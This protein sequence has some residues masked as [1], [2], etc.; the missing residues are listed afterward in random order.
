[1][2]ITQ[3]IMQ[4]KQIIKAVFTTTIAFVI[5]S[6]NSA[7]KDKEATNNP[8]A[9]TA[10]ATTPPPPPPT[11]DTTAAPAVAVVKKCFSND[12]LKYNTVITVNYISTSEVDGSVTSQEMGSDKKEVVKFTGKVSGDKL[13]IK[14]DGK[15]PVIGDASEW[16]NNPW[17][18][19]NK[20]GK[21]K[22]H[23]IFNAKNYETNKWGDTSYEFALSDCK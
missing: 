7:K 5:I 14:F 16:T 18:I 22:L 23:I 15:P 17:S 20:V 9:D 21:E 10:A 6:C 1:M 8:G 3:T 19:D 11:I 2:L 12:G 4:T 13:T